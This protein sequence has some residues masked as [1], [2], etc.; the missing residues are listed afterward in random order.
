MPDP[1][2]EALARV[3]GEAA[4]ARETP[5]VP[6]HPILLE[7]PH[8]LEEAELPRG[9]KSVA[10]KVDVASWTIAW[11]GART[12]ELEE[13][14]RGGSSVGLRFCHRTD[15]R[16]GWAVWLRGGFAGAFMYHRPGAIVPEKLGASRLKEVLSSG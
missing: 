4:T 12:E 8:E 10:R 16:H 6:R 2:R 3:R 13:P 7:P 9:P 14:K 11:T 1:I 5:P 15:G